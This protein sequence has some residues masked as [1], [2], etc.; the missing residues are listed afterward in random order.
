MLVTRPEPGGSQTASR[1]LAA[2]YRPVLAPFL[3][4]RPCRVALP[5]PARL[6]AVVVASGN[7]VALLARYHALPLLAVGDSTAARA[8]AAGFTQV[9]SASGD[10]ADLAALAA[11]T[12]QAADG[13]V[14]LAAGFG[15]GMRLARALRRQGLLVH[16]R[17]VYAA[18]AAR[19]FPAAAGSA[20]AAGLH[21]AL[22]FSAATA[23]AFVRLLPRGLQPQLRRTVALAIGPAAAT[24][25]AALPWR[26]LRV[27]AQ[28]TQEG[29][30]ALL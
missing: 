4:V 22:F 26:D 8:R 17:A 10:A 14:L 19:A 12:L 7:A 24:I 11:R 29:I 23:H 6:Q 9:T 18:A 3:A 5:D 25:L 28:P 30:L 1:L 2:G 20:I 13:P 15:Q 21:A 27:A 16:R